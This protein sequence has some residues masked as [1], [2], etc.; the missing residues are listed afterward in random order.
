MKNLKLRNVQDIVQRKISVG[1]CYTANKNGVVKEGDDVT[2]QY[3]MDV[4]NHEWSIERNFQYEVSYTNC[5]FFR[6]LATCRNK[7]YYYLNS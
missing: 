1:T 5:I 2:K 3:C 6:F 4:A 7:N